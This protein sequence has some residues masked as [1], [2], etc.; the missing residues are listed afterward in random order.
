L[1]C[2]KAG[3]HWNPYGTLFFPSSL[4]ISSNVW[5]GTLHGARHDPIDRRH[6]GDLGNIWWVFFFHRISA[7]NFFAFIFSRSDP[8]GNAIINFEDFIIQL[9]PRSISSILDKSI[10][11]HKDMDD[12]GRGMY[13]DSQ[14][15]G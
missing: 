15:T 8:F 13:S 11:V 4:A 3:E 1:N 6:V 10:V 9:D 2:S 14:T 5:L 12:L 7:A